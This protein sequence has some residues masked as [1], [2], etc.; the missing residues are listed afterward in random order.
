MRSRNPATFTAVIIDVRSH[1]LVV[2][3]PDVLFTGMIHVSR[4]PDDFYT[5]DPVRLQFRGKRGRNVFELGARLAVKVCRVDAFKKQVD[6]EPAQSDTAP[7]ENRKP[8]QRE[9]RSERNKGHASRTKAGAKG[10]K[11]APKTGK[12]ARSP[13]RRKR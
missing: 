8:A 7:G 11:Q 2:E 10:E 6:F 5:F 12:D 13:K 3:L 9:G 1:G 4:L